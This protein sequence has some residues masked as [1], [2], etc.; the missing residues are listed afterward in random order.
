MSER[1][2]SGRTAIVT[3]GARGIGAAHAR[4][5]H[6]AGAFVVIGDVLEAEGRATAADLGERAA[7]V[8]LDVTVEAQW[9]EA[10]AAAAR[11]SG[12]PVTI[13]INNAGMNRPEP[14]ESMSLEHWNKVVGVNLT[15][16]FLGTKAVIEPMRG[17]GGGAIVNTSSM[18][19]HERPSELAPYVAAKAGVIGL[20]QVSAV[21]LAPYG[22]RVNAL[23]PGFIATEMAPAANRAQNTP[24]IPLRRYGEPE[25]VA[26][27]MLFLV[28]DGD[29]TTGGQYF[30]DGGVL[31]GRERPAR[32][33]K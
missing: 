29:Y 31:A 15:G 22:I 23:V 26:A 25:D 4:A 20:T 6:G 7:F 9:D 24:R 19:V 21:E 13:L 18:T 30:V 10:V 5:L 2:L 16:H 27:M 14:I 12:Q 33:P 1:T 11:L 3:G 8:P 17:A 28:R 32:Q